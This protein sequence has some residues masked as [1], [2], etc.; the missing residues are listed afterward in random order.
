MRTN[1]V[2]AEPITPV[3]MSGKSKNVSVHWL[4]MHLIRYL[5]ETNEFCASRI[6]EISESS[7]TC[8]LTEL[9]EPSA[10]RHQ[11]LANKDYKRVWMAKTH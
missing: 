2:P 7:E 1:Q 5:K 10:S 3:K 6:K 8:S 4:F 11:T 9:E